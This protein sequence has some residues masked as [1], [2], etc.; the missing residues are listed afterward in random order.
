MK[1]L[2]I[3]GSGIISSACSELAGNQGLELYLLNRG[4]STRPVPAGAHLLQGDIRDRA[5]A[6]KALG[7]MTFDAVVDWVAFTPSTSKPTPRGSWSTKISTSSW[8]RLL[9]LRSP[10]GRKPLVSAR[11]LK[12]LTSL[13]RQGPRRPK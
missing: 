4:Q 1:V 9:P 11:N 7:E 12:P 10:R 2:S 8:T 5:S 13:L 3:G 6:T